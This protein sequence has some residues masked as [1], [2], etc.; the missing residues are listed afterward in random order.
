M[1]SGPGDRNQQC[2]TDP[3]LLGPA[4]SMGSGPGDRN[5]WT[6]RNDQAHANCPTPQWGPVLGTGIRPTR[7]HGKS[8]PGRLNGVRSWGPESAPR[9]HHLRALAQAS[10]G[11]GPGDRNQQERIKDMGRR[12]L[13]RPQWGPVLGTGISTRSAAASSPATARGLNGVRSWGPESADRSS[14]SSRQGCWRLNGVRS[15]GPESGRGCLA[16]ALLCIGLN[17]V[18]SW[19]PESDGSPTDQRAR[20]PTAPQWGPVLGTGISG[21]RRPASAPPGR[22]GLN[23]VRSWGPESELPATLANVLG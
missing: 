10:M 6:G 17:G 12:D 11:S 19:G 16:C 2:V 23:G 7:G 9:Q 14:P 20:L 3:L 15:W 1:G 18:R 4:A 8:W 21:P 22:S 13:Q 5:Q